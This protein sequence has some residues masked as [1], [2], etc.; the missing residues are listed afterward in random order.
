MRGPNRES[1][2][3]IR[4]ICTRPTG[5][6]IEHGAGLPAGS[7]PADRPHTGTWAEAMIQQRGPHGMRVLHGLL[8]L[9]EKHPV[10]GTGTGGRE[11]PASR[12]LALAR[13]ARAAG[14]GRPGPATGLSGNSPLIRSS[15]PIEAL[16]PDCFTPSTLNPNL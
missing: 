6:V 10:G 8:P 4:T 13:S 7:R 5:S 11:S 12:H 14:T 16:T 15:T 1:S 9:A 2:P 3:P